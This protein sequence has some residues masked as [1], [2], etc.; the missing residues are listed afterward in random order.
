MQKLWNYLK[1]E[2]QTFKKMNVSK[3]ISGQI[4]KLFFEAGVKYNNNVVFSFAELWALSPLYIRLQ[5]HQAANE[6]VDVAIIKENNDYKTFQADNPADA[7]GLAF[8]YLLKE[9][10]IVHP[11]ATTEENFIEKKTRQPKNCW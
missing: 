10:L 5:K 7:L 9:G 1:I 4:R 3:E 6:I 11:E 2:N 8:V